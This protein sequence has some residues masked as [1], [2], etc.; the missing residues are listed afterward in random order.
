[1]NRDQLMFEYISALFISI[2]L[3]L[4]KNNVKII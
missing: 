2:E 1:M 4:I 3:I